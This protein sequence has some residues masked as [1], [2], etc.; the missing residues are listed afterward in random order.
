MNFSSVVRLRILTIGNAFMVFI[1]IVLLTFSDRLFDFDIR[2]E[3]WDLALNIF[4]SKYNYLFFGVP[5]NIPLI[6]NG[7]SFSD[8]MFLTFLFRIG[9]IGFSLFSLFYLKILM[10]SIVIIAG[11][12]VEKKIYAAFLMTSS[13]LM[14]YSD[15]LYF[16]PIMLLH[17]I[18]AGVVLRRN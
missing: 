17:G 13:I 15:F 6:K 14:F 18:S 4:I 7:V 1:F 16:Y 2:F 11:T 3:K 10:R 8:N 12:S 5:E 9:I